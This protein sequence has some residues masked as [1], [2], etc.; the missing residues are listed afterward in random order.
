MTTILTVA[1]DHGCSVGET[2]NQIVKNGDD[3][4]IEVT[5]RL[6]PENTKEF[7]VNAIVD[8]L[9]EKTHAISIKILNHH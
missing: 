8:E 5:F 6:S 4:V 2:S 1:N 3:S 7:D 9:K